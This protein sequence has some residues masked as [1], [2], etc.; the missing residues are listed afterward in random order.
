[1][2]LGILAYAS[3]TGL[4]I[5][6]QN[7]YRFLQ[8][9]KTLLIDLSPLNHLPV[10]YTLFTTDQIGEVQICKGVPQYSDVVKFCK[11]ID[12]LFCAETPL[13]YFIFN[14]CKEMGIKTVLHYNY[15]F[16]DYLNQPKLPKP[17]LLI[18]PTLWHWSEMVN[19][20][21]DW[22]VDL[23]YIPVG[24]DRSVL[25]YKP[26]SK[27]R[28]FLHIAG[29]TT[30]EDRNGTEIVHQAIKLVRNPDLRFTIRAQHQVTTLPSDRRVQ[31]IVGDVPN[32][33]DLYDEM[34]CLLFPRRYG[35]LCLPLNEAMSCGMIPLMTNIE[36]QNLFLPSKC[37]VPGR[38][39]KILQTRTPI[40]VYDA[41]PIE[42]AAKIEELASL[43]EEDA[44]LLSACMDESAAKLDWRQIKPRL[45]AAFQAVK[46]GSVAV[47]DSQEVA[48]VTSDTTA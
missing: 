43:P 2:R 27:L 31:T 10:D 5:Q 36:P 42:L 1:M 7:Y 26:K 32:Y 46:E 9:H 3:P 34:D 8:P 21:A 13:N 35:G 24:I 23:T 41:T 11:D 19:N 48:R 28:N 16:L 22:G 44:L 29:H 14:R 17:D 25:P 20:A 18:A 15:E 45:E 39:G 38:L 47:L 4:G 30:A 33:Y 12:V 6:T 37:L 40:G